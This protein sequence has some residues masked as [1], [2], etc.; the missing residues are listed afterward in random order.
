MCT[1]VRPLSHECG[2]RSQKRFERRN[3]DKNRLAP[4]TKMH[5]IR[6]RVLHG[7]R[8]IIMHVCSRS[9]AAHHGWKEQQSAKTRWK[10][11]N[12]RN[13]NERKIASCAAANTHWKEA[14]F[15]D[16][17]SQTTKTKRPKVEGDTSQRSS[18]HSSTWRTG[19]R[20]R[21][22]WRIVWVASIGRGVPGSRQVVEAV[23]MLSV[24]GLS[25]V[26]AGPYQ[27]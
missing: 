25:T 2:S 10:M 6:S 13:L 20:L 19:H 5:Y 9:D 12:S 15:C 4:K 16:T 7:E 1:A 21:L 11:K 17:Y 3:L 14:K 8:N 27:V 23:I 24:Q 26:S 18:A 22:R